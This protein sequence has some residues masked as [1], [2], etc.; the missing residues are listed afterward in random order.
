MMSVLG[1]GEDDLVFVL[2]ALGFR[3]QSVK[4][5]AG[6]EPIEWSS[7][8]RRDERRAKPRAQK[9]KR[10]IMASVTP[11]GAPAETTPAAASETP[12]REPKRKERK[13]QRHDEKP[14]PSR[15][16]EKAPVADPD[17]PFAVLAALKFR[18]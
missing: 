12:A 6:E 7:R 9:P 15:R 10:A 18:K 2:R 4:N 11:Y 17:S 5:Q 3:D 1:C 16:P 8:T 13:P 14:R